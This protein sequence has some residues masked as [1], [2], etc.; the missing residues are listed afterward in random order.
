[1]IIINIKKNGIIENSGKKYN[2]KN[3]KKKKLKLVK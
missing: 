2:I 1:M 3:Y